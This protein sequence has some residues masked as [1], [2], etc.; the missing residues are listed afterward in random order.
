MLIDRIKSKP[1]NEPTGGLMGY[2]QTG[3]SPV[4]L[5]T[6]P[7]RNTLVISFTYMGQKAFPHVS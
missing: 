5:R 1:K 6:E 4:E 7:L 3:W 2:A